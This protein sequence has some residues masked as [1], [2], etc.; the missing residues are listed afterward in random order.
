MAYFNVVFSICLIFEQ[1]VGSVSGGLLLWHRLSQDLF[2][3]FT[4]KEDGREVKTQM[5]GPF[6]KL[7]ANII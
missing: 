2:V 4:V 5:R 3:I 6:G 7:G 1:L